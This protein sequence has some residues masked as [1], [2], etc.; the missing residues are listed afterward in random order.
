VIN[1]A[2]DRLLA[3]RADE[4]AM[5]AIPFLV[6]EV[7]GMSPRA[8][9]PIAAAHRLWW[10]AAHVFDDVIDGGDLTYADSLGP[11]EAVMASVVCAST[12]PLK[13]LAAD[14]PHDRLP[15]VL[16][17]FFDAWVMSNDGQLLDLAN[18]LGGDREAVLKSYLHKNGAAYGMACAATARLAGADDQRVQQWRSF[19][20]SLGLLGQFRNDQEDLTWDRDEDLRTG[21]MTYLLAHVIHVHQD[22]EHT[23]DFVAH[24]SCVAES[25]EAREA[26]KNYMLQPAALGG[27]FSLVAAL[28]EATLRALRPLAGDYPQYPALRRIVDDAARPLPD[29]QRRLA[30]E[31][32]LAQSGWPLCREQVVL[33]TEDGAAAGVEDKALVHHSDTPLHLAFSSYLFNN[34]GEVLVSQRA[35]AKK[36]WP[37]IWTNSAC[38]HPAPGEELFSAVRR[39]VHAELGVELLD[40]KLVLPGFRYRAVMDNGVV[41]NEWCPVFCAQVTGEAVIDA[42]EV[43]AVEW[44]P[45]NIFVQQVL[46]GERQVSPWCVA[47]VPQLAALGSD[48]KLWKS[49]VEGLPAAARPSSLVASAAT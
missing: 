27:Y 9:V 16:G 45:W 35:W 34:Q 8:A 29:F 39:R 14:L 43:Q 18:R 4:L 37:G 15:A 49:S 1:G 5:L 7:E 32:R 24:L 2:L 36:T 33:L 22:C 11:G 47:Q 44:V 12:L 21:T 25:S 13:I 3:T 48:P 6:A 30:E 19:G 40:L 31:G 46:K 23:E 38:G 28:H 42:S 41:E 17:E 10:T 20:C 26:V